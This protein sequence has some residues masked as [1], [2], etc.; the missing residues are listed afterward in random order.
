MGVPLVTQ[1]WIRH[2]EGELHIA[3]AQHWTRGQHRQRRREGGWMV[4][5]VLTLI[6]FA[7]FTGYVIE[8]FLTHMP[9]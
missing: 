7:A 3:A 6:G 4:I 1:D 5:A 8:Q 9:G 2:L